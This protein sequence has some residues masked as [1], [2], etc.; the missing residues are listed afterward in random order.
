MNQ[1]ASR[2]IQTFDT[3]LAAPDVLAAAKRFFARRTG[4]Y[5][6]F[7][8]KEGPTHVAM[9]GQGGEEVLV[10]VAPIAGGTRVTGSTYLFDQQVARFLSSLPVLDAPV[11]DES[12]PPEDG[13]TAAAAV[14]P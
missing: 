13:A 10:G 1:Q 12:A 8:E 6:A 4:I 14:A 3:T 9:R 7:I 2:T 11:P 5:S